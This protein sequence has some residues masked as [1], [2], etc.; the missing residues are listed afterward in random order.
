[1]N[2]ERERLQCNC[3]GWRKWLRPWDWEHERIARRR[4]RWLGS[5]PWFRQIQAYSRL[6]QPGSDHRLAGPESRRT[7]PVSLSVG[8]S[9]SLRLRRTP[10]VWNSA[11]KNEWVKSG[12]WFLLSTTLRKDLDSF[13]LVFFIYFLWIDNSNV[14]IKVLLPNNLKICH[15]IHGLS[16]L[17]KRKKKEKKK[18]KLWIAHRW[19]DQNLSYLRV[20]KNLTLYSLEVWS[21]FKLFTYSLKFHDTSVLL[22]SF[23]NCIFIFFVFL[24]KRGIKVK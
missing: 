4:H 18:G 6:G 1:M 16:S 11:R 20:I 15:V 17:K 19:F 9:A 24:E 7:T 2:C 3:R 10:F 21:K 23:W 14:E 22:D 5:S 12:F 13:V 8:P